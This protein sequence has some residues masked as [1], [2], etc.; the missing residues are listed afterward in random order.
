MFAKLNN[1]R[2][3]LLQVDRQLAIALPHLNPKRHGDRRVEH[4]ALFAFWNAA[5]RRF[6]A[7]CPAAP[8]IHSLLEA[9]GE[10]TIRNDHVALRTFNLENVNRRLVGDLFERHGYQRVPE[11][12]NFP[13]KQLTADY[14]IH[15]DEFQ[16]KVFISEL[17]VEAMPEDMQQW[18]RS[19]TADCRLEGLG[20]LLAPTWRP[21]RYAD[22][23]R[24][25]PQSEYAAWT[26]A[27]GIQINHFAILCNQLHK[28]H[29]L[30]S[31]NRWLLV[32]GFQLN[33]AGGAVKGSERELLLQSATM[34]SNVKHLFAE[35]YH[36][37]P[38]CFYEFAQR[39]NIECSGTLYQGF[40]ADNA[41]KIFESTSKFY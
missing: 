27:F 39:F 7:Q 24:F 40:R 15:P 33:M 12:L 30:R 26:A 31:L 37:V 14:Y 28:F 41:S 32:N 38:A 13:D 9:A 34:A 23:C 8:S 25:A 2:Q 21:V 10:K 1:Y 20:S 16:P 18:I 6:A 3:G 36:T 4:N 17:S 35:G 11:V 29:Q 5:W 19:V 22:Y